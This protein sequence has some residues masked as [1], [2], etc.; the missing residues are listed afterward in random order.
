MTA[1]R[2]QLKILIPEILYTLV[3]AIFI[4]KLNQLNRYLLSNHLDQDV[5][6]LLSHNDYEPVKYF[7]GTMTLGLFGAAWVIYIVKMIQRER[8][9]YKELILAILA[10]ALTVVVIILLIVFIDNPIL[11]AVFAVLVVLLGGGM[12]LFSKNE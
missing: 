9:E 10:I 1:S 12:T 8:M 6:A 3:S 5:F 11:R 2:N 4:F 7:I